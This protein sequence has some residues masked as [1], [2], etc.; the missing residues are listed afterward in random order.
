M[1]FPPYFNVWSILFRKGA[2]LCSLVGENRGTVCCQKVVGGGGTTD[3]NDTRMHVWK[4]IEGWLQSN[5]APT[6]GSRIT[7]LWN[8]LHSQPFFGLSSN[9]ECERK[10]RNR[11]ILARFMAFMLS[12][13]GESR[14]NFSVFSALIGLLVCN[15]RFHIFFPFQV[16]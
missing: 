13:G 2:M 5:N 14:L 11:E 6:E 1:I 8:F 15:T 7:C 3:K 9:I 12:F 10:D 16:L 4:T